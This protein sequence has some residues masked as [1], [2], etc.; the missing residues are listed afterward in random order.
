MYSD[1]SAPRQLSK[2]ECLTLMTSVPV[3]RII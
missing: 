2:D 3:G 1:G